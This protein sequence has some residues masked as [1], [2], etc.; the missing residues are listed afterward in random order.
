MSRYPKTIENLITELGRLPGVGPK[1]AERYAFALLKRPRADR[2]RLAAAVLAPNAGLMTCSACR[3]L[4]EADPCYLCADPKRERDLLCVVATE[5]D[6]LAVE[7]TGEYRGLYHVLGGFLS[8]MEGVTPD[9]LTVR[10]LAQRVREA[11]PRE[12]LF[13]FDQTVE[14]E[15]TVMYLARLLARDGLRLT[16][17]ARGLPLGSE[18]NYADELTLT[19][20]LRERR[21]MPNPYPKESRPF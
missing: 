9:D 19:G 8:A 21:E 5:Q 4:A 3:N 17:L 1:T 2:E 12:I 15:A 20:A 14:G 10:E 18:I 13:A 6:L 11:P 16:R 7:R